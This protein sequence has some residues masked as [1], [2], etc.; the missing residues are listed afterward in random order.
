MKIEDVLEDF[1]TPFK[2]TSPPGT[3]KRKA[4]TYLGKVLGENLSKQDLRKVESKAKKIKKST[5]KAERQQNH[6]LVKQLDLI[7]NDS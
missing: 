6:Q 1:T 2:P 4:L 3:I 5:I 7:T